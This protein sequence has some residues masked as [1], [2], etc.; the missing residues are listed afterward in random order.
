[1]PPSHLL[2]CS[3]RLGVSVHLSGVMLSDP[4]SDPI[5]IHVCRE[6]AKHR[7]STLRSVDMSQAPIT[8]AVSL[9]PNEEAT[10]AVKLR[11]KNA[12]TGKSLPGVSTTAVK[13]Q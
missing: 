10:S 2:G 3:A 4:T 11:L 8:G 6:Q 1:L 9:L 7:R 5:F 12:A 13:M